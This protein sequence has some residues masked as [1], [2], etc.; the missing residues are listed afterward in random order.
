MYQAK[1][2]IFLTFSN[3]LRSYSKSFGSPGQN[4]LEEFLKL[5][6]ISFSMKY[7]GA[8]PLQFLVQLSKTA[9]WVASWILAFNFRQC[10][11]F[12]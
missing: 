10:R 5:G 2:E 3:L 4:I 7:L 6:K 9:F 1:C 8:D 12:P 11:G